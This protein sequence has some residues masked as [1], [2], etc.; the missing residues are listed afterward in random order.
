MS[1]ETTSPVS[2]M[3]T[4]PDLVGKRHAMIVHAYYPVGETR[5]Q[6]EA[7]ALVEQ[8]MSVDVICLRDAGEPR[9]ETVDGVDVRRLPIG[10]N[11][12]LGVAFQLIEYLVFLLA[13]SF[14]VSALHLRRR[15]HSV[16][17]HNLPDFLVFSAVVPKLTG[18]RLLLDLHDLMPEFL[19]ARLDVSMRHPLVRLV[20]LQERLSCRF[21][22]EVI[23][24]TDGWRQRLIERGVRADKISVVMNVADPELFTRRSGDPDEDTFT[25]VY[26]G[27]F[28]HRYGVD[29]LVE[30]ADLLRSR[31]PSLRVW[32]LGD[33]EY[34]HELE[35]SVSRL[36]LGDVVTLSDGMLGVSRLRPH[37]ERA[38]V[39]VVPNR[40]SVFTDD[41][42]PTKLLE[43]VAVGIPVVVARAPMIESYF[44]DQMVEYFT[45]GDASDLADKL[46]GLAVAPERRRSLVAAAARFEDDHSWER[47]SAEYASVVA[48]PAADTARRAG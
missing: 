19:A 22:D 35:D 41:L 18:A 40:S 17:V 27:T 42:L 13:A 23:T 9:F 5:V 1:S 48:G 30:A 44:D 16:Q 2:N 10:R 25:V 31:V 39:G 6:R 46:A 47:I 4:R 14:W 21:A 43:Y 29:L 37:L 20:S 34:R 26:H 12:R 32:L 45:P 11:R 38:D 15:Y 8:G 24:V 28:T 36:G 7:A 3:A 33:G